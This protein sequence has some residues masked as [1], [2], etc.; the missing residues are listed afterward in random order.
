MS[1]RRKNGV[2]DNNVS[3]K[4]NRQSFLDK[5][6][7]W[8]SYFPFWKEGFYDQVFLRKLTIVQF[9]AKGQVPEAIITWK[10]I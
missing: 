10:K 7:K 4:K 1:G 2:D 3:C 9:I 6:K 5:I 8:E